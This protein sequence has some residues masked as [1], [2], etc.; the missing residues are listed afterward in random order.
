MRV[1]ASILCC[2]ALAFACSDEGSGAGGRSSQDTSKINVNSDF[3]KLVRGALGA[4]QH[5]VEATCPCR[6]EEGAFESNEECLERSGHDDEFADCVADK[7]KPSEDREMREALHCMMKRYQARAACT[8]E[9]G[10][11]LDDVTACTDELA[12]CPLLDPQALTRA[13]QGCPGGSLLGR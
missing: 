13:L 10:C 5:E 7:L 12:E 9:N 3:R 1:F 8:E 6:V 11:D 4:Y 2:S